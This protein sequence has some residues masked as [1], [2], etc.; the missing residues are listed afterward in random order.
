MREVSNEDLE[1]MIIMATDREAGIGR[2]ITER[3]S[4][5]LAAH[6]VRRRFLSLRPGAAAEKGSVPE[7]LE[8]DRVVS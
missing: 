5:V 4:E 3:E 1:I 7:C 2:P 8:P 6:N